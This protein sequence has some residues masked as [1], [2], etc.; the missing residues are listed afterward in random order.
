MRPG[1][2]IVGLALAGMVLGAAVLAQEPAMPAHNYR[3]VGYYAAWTVYRDFNVADIPAEQLTHLNYAF[4][5]ISEDGEIVPGDPWADVEM[6]DPNDKTGAALQGNFRQLLLLKEAYPHLQTMI[7]VGG[8]SWSER[9]SD[10]AL[11]AESRAKFAR[12][13]VDFI[14]RYGFDGVDLDW[15]YPTGGGD[16]GNVERPED[17]ENF[18]L[19]LEEVRAQLDAQGAT[20]GRHY[21]L[22]SAVGAG[23]SA[24]EPL[25]WSRIHPLLDFINVMTYDM[26]G[27]WSGVTGFNAPLYD[28]AE[29]PP[30][31]ASAD[32]ALT[33]LIAL[34][35][36]RDKLV[37][38]VP[39]YGRGWA[40]VPDHNNGLHQP[41]SGLPAGTREQG[42]YDY[43][44]LAANYI[45][46]A[47]RHW[48][49]TAMVPWLYDPATRVM[50]SYDDPQS[51]S[52]KAAYVR[53]HG[54]G[55]IMIWELS[56]DDGSLL[57]AIDAA[58]GGG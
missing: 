21:L 31:G 41:F 28:S 26:A 23:R 39:F 5:N 44:D 3:V 18:I 37:M 19:L 56:T 4:A 22:T 45:T 8:W 30:E 34:G 38:G 57:A 52:A 35:V 36:P 46:E 40:N 25:D 54:L 50:I 32:T 16:P 12:S 48:H 49:E 7:S 17:P 33:D 27:P 42:S 11:T 53:E 10:V 47:T 43:A 6:P 2:L 14:T 15:E 20:D 13:A 29:N 55:G 58:L 51:L 9:F 1:R 24:Y